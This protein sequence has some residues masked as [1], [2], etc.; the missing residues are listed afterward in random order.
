VA[1]YINEAIEKE[2]TKSITVD[3]AVM[4]SMIFGKSIE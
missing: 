2:K 3:F 4:E 1:S